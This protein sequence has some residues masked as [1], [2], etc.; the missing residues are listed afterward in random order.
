[1]Q[2]QAGGEPV[3]RGFIAAAYNF[4]RL[5]VVLHSSVW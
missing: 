4:Q 2:A 5:P 3:V 1:M